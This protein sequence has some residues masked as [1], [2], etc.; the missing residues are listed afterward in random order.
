MATYQTVLIPSNGMETGIRDLSEKS[1]NKALDLHHRLMV[2]LFLFT[3]HF[4]F[5]LFEWGGVRAKNS[6]LVLIRH[7]IVFS[8]S[9]LC[10]FAFGFHIAYAKGGEESFVF[11][12][13]V[14]ETE[15]S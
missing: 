4:G 15:H 9:S 1:M 2:A 6:D 12:R 10:I 5:T 13:N 8:I 14:L 7:F 11:A 3:F